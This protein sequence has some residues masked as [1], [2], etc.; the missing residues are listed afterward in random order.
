MFQQ[1][2][3]RNEKCL[4]PIASVSLDLL[5]FKVQ[6]CKINPQKAL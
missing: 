1:P 6:N 4:P 5:V 3:E 2:G